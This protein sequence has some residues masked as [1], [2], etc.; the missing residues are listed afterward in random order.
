[1]RSATKRAN[2]L[3]EGKDREWEPGMCVEGI[4]DKDGDC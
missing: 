3:S 4:V 2:K 1:M